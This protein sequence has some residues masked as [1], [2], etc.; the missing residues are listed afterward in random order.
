MDKKEKDGKLGY[1]VEK[2][3]RD[4]FTRLKED[5]V[6]LDHAGTALYSERQLRDA[7]ADMTP[8]S[9][10]NPHSKGPSSMRTLR[11]VSES[12]KMIL[13]HFH[14]NEKEYA[15]I[16]TSGATE[17]LKTVGLEFRVARFASISSSES[18]LSGRC[19]GVRNGIQGQGR[20]CN[21]LERVCRIL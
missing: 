6:F 15:V 12:R 2:L 4:E 19:A 11:R 9:A 18:Q 21:V 3:R 8:A 16:F 7:I 17:A 20:S 14:T 5:E 1:D 13:D 10:R